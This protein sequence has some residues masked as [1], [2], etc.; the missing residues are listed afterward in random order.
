MQNLATNTD[1]KSFKFEI[2]GA[3]QGVGFRPFVYRICADLG[4]FGKV[5]NDGEGV[6][7]FVNGSNLQIKE[8]KK[9]LKAE[10]PPLARIDRLEIYEISPQIYDDFKITH[11]QET[12]K[13]NP[14]LPDFAICDDCKREFYDPQ[15]KRYKYPYINCTNCG[16]RLS[17]I[18]KLPYDRANTTMAK[19]KMCEFC[20]GEYTDPLNR[21]YH[22][23]PIACA[24]CGPKLFLKNK[25]GEIL[26]SGENAVKMLC[27]IL[28]R[29]EIVAVKGLG[30]FHIMCDATNENAVLNLRIRK[31]RPDKPFAIMCKDYEMAEKFGKF[32]ENE[33]EL[34]N[35]QIKPIVL[36]EKSKNSQNFALADAVAPNLGKV[37]IFLANTGVHLLI[38]EYFNRPL[39]ATSANISG[40]PIIFDEINLRQKLGKVIDF[41]LDNDR[42][43]ITPSDDSVGFVVQNSAQCI[44][45]ITEQNSQNIMQNFT[46]FLRTSRGLNPQIYKSKFDIKGSFLALGA[47]MKNQFAI[48]K[49]GQIFISPY[50]GDLKNIATNARFFALL[51]IFIKTYDLKFDAVLGDLHPIFLHSKHFENLGFKVVKFQ[52]H[53]AHLVANLA[54]NNL[55]GS[56]KKYLGFSFDGTGYGE[57]G[58]IWGGEVLEFDE[59]EFER[60]LHFDEFAL[61]GGENS[62]KNIYKLAISLIFKFDLENEAS[63]FLSKF[64]ESEISNLKKVASNSPQTSSLG[65][66]FDAFA[67]VICGQR[68]VSFDGQSGMVLENLFD[69]KKITSESEKRY[70]FEIINGK[71]SVKNAFL[72]ALKDELSVAASNFINSIAKIMLQIAKDRKLEV[73]LSGGVFQNATL[74]NLVV[75]KFSDSG[76]KFYLHKNT[77]SNDSGVAIGQLMAYLSALNKN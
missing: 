58:T 47:E 46:Q 42:E 35:S 41:Y 17:I 62:I 67:S 31:N 33:K 45:E 2:F 29:G 23:E 18:K 76:V 11:S 7:I 5:F 55:L 65:R 8:L 37:G 52:H 30:G 25:N 22:A 50:I 12:Q 59:F 39:I 10:L 19:F 70:K 40:E 69:E 16:P 49:D 53:Y 14:I 72:N 75:Q 21:R 43:I 3:V 34:L 24:K 61:I 9:R 60:V 48:Y 4:L 57:D 74:L 6:K 68:S 71:I 66:I 73:V 15:N 20:A 56:G 13:F 38:F 51:D 26:E 64:S 36:V 27:E 44:T 28:A 1:L 77:P 54:D 32:C 63:E